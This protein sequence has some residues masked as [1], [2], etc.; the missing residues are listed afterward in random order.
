MDVFTL[1]ANLALLA[2][3]ALLAASCAQRQPAESQTRSFNTRGVVKEVRPT[4]L[5]IDH[6][7]IPDYMDAMTMP[8]NVKD[9]S[10]VAAVKP[11]DRISF[12][13]VVTESESWIDQIVRLEA[14]K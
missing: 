11:G 10:S 3:F 2:L 9:K 12:R 4:S 8:F 7:A 5:V 1:R 6:E 13:L 14:G